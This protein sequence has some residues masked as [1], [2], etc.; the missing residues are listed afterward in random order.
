MHK[1]PRFLQAF[2]HLE[3]RISLLLVNN[4]QNAPQNKFEGVITPYLS[5]EQCFICLIENHNLSRHQ[6]SSPGRNLANGCL[7]DQGEVF[8]YKLVAHFNDFFATRGENLNKPIFRSANA[9]EWDIEAS[10]SLVHY[11][12]NVLK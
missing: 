12:E 1:F 7:A 5:S 3:D 9:R 11:L 6:R 8:Q 2:T 4:F 10:I